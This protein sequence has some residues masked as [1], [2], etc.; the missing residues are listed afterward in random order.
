M[1]CLNI[2]KIKYKNYFLRQKLIEIGI[3]ILNFLK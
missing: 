3:C 2:V 1:V